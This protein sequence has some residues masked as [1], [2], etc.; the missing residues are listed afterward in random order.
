MSEVSSLINI[1]IAR[2]YLLL[3]D[4]DKAND[5]CENGLK[6]RPSLSL[7]YILYNLVII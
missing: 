2:F 5:Y 4:I 6:I 3:G 1:E 7:G